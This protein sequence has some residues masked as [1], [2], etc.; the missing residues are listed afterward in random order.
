[1]VSSEVEGGSGTDFVPKFIGFCTIVHW[2]L[3][4]KF[5]QPPHLSFCSSALA[6]ASLLSTRPLFLTPHRQNKQIRIRDW[7]AD[8]L[9]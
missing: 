2:I 8:Y 4:Y 5:I 1:M 7:V 6:L 3:Y 9:R